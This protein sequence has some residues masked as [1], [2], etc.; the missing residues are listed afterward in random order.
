M[1]RAIKTPTALRK[2][3][4]VGWEKWSAWHRQAVIDT[5]HAWWRDTLR[6]GPVHDGRFSAAYPLDVIFC[7][8]ID[9]QPLLDMWDEDDR[10][11]A[12]LWLARWL[13][14]DVAVAPNRPPLPNAFLRDRDDLQ[15]IALEWLLR[16]VVGERL[17]AA[18]FR[19]G[20]EEDR[21]MVSDGE[22]VWRALRRAASEAVTSPRRG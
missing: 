10:M 21:A 1:R 18:F 11:P 4:Y 20:N 14:E 5:L 19:A 22:A 9:P 3:P 17:T 12:T 7:A 15:K 8:E 13:R 2:L 6:R 16:P